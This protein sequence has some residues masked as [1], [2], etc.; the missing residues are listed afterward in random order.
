MGMERR[1]EES[2]SLIQTRLTGSEQYFETSGS[3]RERQTTPLVRE[4][5]RGGFLEGK[6]AQGASQG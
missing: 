3:S 1:A 6:E 5:R 2:R 4:K